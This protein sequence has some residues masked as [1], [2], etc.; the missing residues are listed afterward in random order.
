MSCLRS[1]S[2]CLSPK[3]ESSQGLISSSLHPERRNIATRF[4]GVALGGARISEQPLGSTFVAVLQCR[5]FP[6]LPS[7]N[8]FSGLAKFP[9]MPLRIVK[10]KDEV[11]QPSPCVHRS[12]KP[13]MQR[14]LSSRAWGSWPCLIVC[15][16]H[17]MEPLLRTGPS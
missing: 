17:F 1:I 5:L 13:S 8:T 15:L 9:G 7:A 11:G 6:V 14:R 16:V 4:S 2:V 12:R 10:A 3:A